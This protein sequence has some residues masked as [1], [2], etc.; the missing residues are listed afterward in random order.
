M[1]TCYRQNKGPMRYPNDCAHEK[2]ME[3]PGYYT[4]NMEEFPIAMAYVP[5]Q[6]WNEQY[7]LNK[8]LQAG[9]IFPELD[10]PYLGLRGVKG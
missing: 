8:A 7:E 1:E 10:K 9:T 2:K 4:K 5:W 3:K 6:Y